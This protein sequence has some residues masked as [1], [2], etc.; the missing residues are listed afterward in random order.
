MSAGVL[1]IFERLIEQWHERVGY[2][3]RFEQYDGKEAITLLDEL[4]RASTQVLARCVG[5]AA[6]VDGSYGITRRVYTPA[7]AES[8]SSSGVL[9][10]FSR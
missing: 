1:T 2:I 6:I 4:H 9:R 8:H 3:E 10:T 7:P 5:S